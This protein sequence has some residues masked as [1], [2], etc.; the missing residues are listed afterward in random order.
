MPDIVQQDDMEQLVTAQNNFGYT[1][2]RLSALG[3]CEYT[4]ATIVVDESGSTEPFRD[5][6][7][8]AVQ[9]AV[10]ACQRDP[11]ADNLLVRVVAFDSKVREIHGFKLLSSINLGDYIG[12]LKKT[13]GQTALYDATTGAIEAA[14]SYG[15][16]LVASDFD[17]NGFTVVI[18]DGLNCAGTLG[19]SSVKAAFEA[20]SKKEAMS[21]MISV[22]VGV[23]V[24]NSE[25]KLK[26]DEFHAQAGF[27]KFIAVE[28]AERTTFAKLAEFISKSISSQSK[29]IAGQAPSQPLM[30]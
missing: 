9:E 3:A 6:M 26:L 23:N 13:G 14:A 16:T 12:C 28:D 25:V 2:T 8:K 29:V 19:M 10:A 27:S 4:L 30:F 24:A 7:E 18:T 5:Y 20:I 11:R 1:G 22:L 17:V 21:G 15:A